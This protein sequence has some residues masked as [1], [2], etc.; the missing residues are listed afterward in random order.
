MVD[1]EV[2]VYRPIRKTDGSSILYWRAYRWEK[3][4]GFAGTSEVAT[5]AGV[6][7]APTE[8]RLKQIAKELGYGLRR[9]EDS[10]RPADTRAG[11]EPGSPAFDHRRP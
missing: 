7:S 3:Q 4:G 8:E 5:T 1:E 10:E 9:V 6:F 11:I 2:L